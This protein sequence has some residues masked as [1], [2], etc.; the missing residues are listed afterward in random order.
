MPIDDKCMVDWCVSILDGKPGGVHVF[1]KVKITSTC[2]TTTVLNTVRTQNIISTNIKH[3]V[4][5]MLFV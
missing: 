1:N 3:I 4:E 5:N 2:S